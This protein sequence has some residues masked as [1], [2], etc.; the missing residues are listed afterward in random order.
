MLNK[1]DNALFISKKFFGNTIL[2]VGEYVIYAIYQ[3][4]IYG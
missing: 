3:I 2:E 1:Y 4:P